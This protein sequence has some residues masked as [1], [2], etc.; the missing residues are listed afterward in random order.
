MAWIQ[1]IKTIECAH[2]WRLYCLYH[3]MPYAIFQIGQ[4]EFLEGTYTSKYEKADSLF[5]IKKGGG[6]WWRKSF[7][8]QGGHIG[9]LCGTF[10]T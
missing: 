9:F 4:E 3:E 7:S 2:V 8:T 10:F 6:L 5:G 1:E